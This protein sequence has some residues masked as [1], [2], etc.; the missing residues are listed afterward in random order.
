VITLFAGGW[1]LFAAWYGRS[2]FLLADAV[3]LLAHMGIYGALLIP[4]RAWNHRGER[5]GTSVVLLV[6]VGVA[7]GIVW[8]S[9]SG[10]V[11]GHERAEPAAYLTSL[12]GL[13][14][15]LVTAW[16]FRDPARRQL[17]FLAAFVHELSDGGVT[18]LALVGAGI[19]AL[20]GWRWID[21]ALGLGLGV[22]LVGW[23]L[24]WLWAHWNA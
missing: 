17:S 2:L 4:R 8:E 12:L 22:W 3:H 13:G 1:E 10:L 11:K 6:V 9:A 16:M 21:S 14:A 15:N 24:K 19:M 23:S 18:V 7:C 20:T 5:V